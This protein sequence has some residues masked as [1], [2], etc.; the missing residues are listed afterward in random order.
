MMNHL[1]VPKPVLLVVGALIMALGLV[2]WFSTSGPIGSTAA[3]EDTEILLSTAFRI[4]RHAN[5]MVAVFHPRLWKPSER[6][7]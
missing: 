7:G 4:S 2:G 5:S 1:R 3:A 6:P